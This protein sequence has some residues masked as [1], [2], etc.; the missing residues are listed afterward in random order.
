[1]PIYEYQCPACGCRF[2]VK[3][4][5]NDRAL[6]RCS[7]CKAVARRQISVVNHTFG[8]RKTDKDEWEKDI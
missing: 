6:V 4:G 8:W 2:E 3:Q 7:K 1:M 5:Y